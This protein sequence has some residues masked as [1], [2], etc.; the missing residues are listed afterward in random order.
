VVHVAIGVDSIL[1]VSHEIDPTCLSAT[2]RA[3]NYSLLSAQVTLVQVLHLEDHYNGCIGLFDP[4]HTPCEH[5]VDGIDSSSTY[6][7]T[8][9]S[10]LGGDQ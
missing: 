5:H 4:D 6:A 2:P 10:G 9:V 7:T 3:N 1:H 8:G